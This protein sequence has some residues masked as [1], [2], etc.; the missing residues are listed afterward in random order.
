M[1]NIFLWDID[2]RH[3]VECFWDTMSIVHSTW[4]MFIV[5]VLFKIVFIQILLLSPEI[6]NYSAEAIDQISRNTLLYFETTR[7]IFCNAGN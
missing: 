7:L 3:I 5:F 4:E 2:F 1:N 6:L